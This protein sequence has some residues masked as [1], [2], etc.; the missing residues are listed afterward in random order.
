LQ[1]GVSL[2]P[3]FTKVRR[4]LQSGRFFCREQEMFFSAQTKEGTSVFVF[5]FTQTKKRKPWH[6]RAS[7]WRD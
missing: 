2:Q 3:P 4:S 1:N 7:R 6:Y 5:H